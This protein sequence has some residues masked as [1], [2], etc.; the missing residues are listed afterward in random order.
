MALCISKPGWEWECSAVPRSYLSI[1]TSLGSFDI[2]L[3][4]DLAPNTVEWL[5][6]VLNEEPDDQ[7][8]YFYRAESVD[9]GYALVQGQFSQST[10]NTTLEAIDTPNI[11]GSV[12]LIPGTSQFF[13]SLSDHHDFDGS[14]T[15]FGNIVDKPGKMLG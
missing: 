11:Q 8:K 10:S 2:L 4:P 5:R 14:F 6:A 13:I 7:D 9:Q 3:Q 15:V 1:D 12:A